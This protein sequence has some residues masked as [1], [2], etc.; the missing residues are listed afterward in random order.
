MLS[1]DR[2]LRMKMGPRRAMF[3]GTAA[4]GF[5]IYRGA[6]AAVCTDG[7][8]VPAA[9]A[10]TPSPIAAILGI[11]RHQQIN[12]TNFPGVGAFVGSVTPVE[13]ETG[14]FAL[15]FVETA[16]TWANKGQP[17]YAV[18]D[19]S[20]SLTETPSGGTA[21]LQVGTFAGLDADGTAYTEI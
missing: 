15:P 7:T 20:V 4:V 17:V 21:R 6:I 10:N 13:C 9:S 1:A 19:E 18:D 8:L 16:P 3:A 11:A 5:A 14:C 2:T 12:T